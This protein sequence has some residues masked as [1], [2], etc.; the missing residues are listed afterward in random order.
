MVPLRSIYLASS[1]P[2]PLQEFFMVFIKGWAS[3]FVLNSHRAGSIN[4]VD[5][6]YS[7]IL[8]TPSPDSI[9]L[10]SGS[11]HLAPESLHNVGRFRDSTLSLSSLPHPPTTPTFL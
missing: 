3:L 5:D 2:D 4:D 9:D 7:R 1:L 11:L 8:D 6:A 10:I